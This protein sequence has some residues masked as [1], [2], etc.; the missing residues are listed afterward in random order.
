[1]A[2]LEMYEIARP[3]DNANVLEYLQHG[4]SYP[5]AARAQ[6]STLAFAS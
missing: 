5:Q 1:V 6:R 2:A 4:P 3:N